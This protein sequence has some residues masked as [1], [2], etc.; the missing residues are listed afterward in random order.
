MLQ[1]L[2]KEH[3]LKSSL[4]QGQ[5]A[6]KAELCQ[7]LNQ[8]GILPPPQSLDQLKKGDLIA[9]IRQ[10][11]APTSTEAPALAQPMMTEDDRVHVYDIPLGRNVMVSDGHQVQA[12]SALTDGPINPHDLLDTHFKDLLRR[13]HSIMEAAQGA[14]ATVQQRLVDEVQSVYRSQGVTIDNKHIEVIVRQMT[15]KVRIED[16]GDT[17]FLPG[18]LVDLP[19]VAKTNAAIAET[20]GMQAQFSPMLLGITKASLNTDS[21]ISAASFQE[22]TRVLTEAAIEGKSDLLRG[23]KENVIIGRLIPAGTGFDGFDDQLRDEVGPHPD[24]LDD[25]QTGYRRLSSLRPD[26]TI[27]IPVPSHSSPVLDDPSD[28]QLRKARGRIDDTS[29]SA[30]AL[31]R[32]GEHHDQGT[33]MFP[34]E[35]PPEKRDDRTEE[36]EQNWQNPEEDED[37]I[38]DS[39]SAEDLDTEP[40]P[41]DEGFEL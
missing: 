36:P 7:K 34:S 38:H 1:K 33:T 35:I 26:Y 14:I 37:L 19:Q 18:E 5:S 9:L 31:T 6:K 10:M 30:A 41:M 28:E 32:P 22:T 29:G 4:Q 3:G 11:E 12:G 15:S 8:A 16:A 39:T 25:D 40:Q 13:R 21:F 24:I 23:L 20:G 2:C 27:E 17:T